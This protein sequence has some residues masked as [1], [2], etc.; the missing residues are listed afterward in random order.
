MLSYAIEEAS[1]IDRLAYDINLNANDSACDF[2]IPTADLP[3]VSRT[4]FGQLFLEQSE[5]ALAIRNRE[6]GPR[7]LG[8]RLL[9]WIEGAWAPAPQDLPEKRNPEWSGNS[10]TSYREPVSNLQDLSGRSQWL[11]LLRE[12]ENRSKF[13]SWSS[14]FEYDVPIRD[15]PYQLEGMRIL[16]LSDIHFVKSS[17]RS[18]LE[19]GYFVD[20]LEKDDQQIDLVLISGDIITVA[21]DDLSPE[22][23]RLFRRISEICP[24]CF[25]VHGNH[26]YHGH[27]PALISREMEKMGFYDINNHHIRITVDDAP[28]NIYGVDDAYFGS[29]RAPK[30]IAENEVNIVLT[31]NLDAIRGNFPKEIDLILSGHTHWGE[32]RVFDGSWIM[33]KWGYCNDLNKHTRHWDVLTNRTASFVHPGLARYY[34]PYPGLRHPPG[35][36]IHTLTGFPA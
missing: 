10:N 3:R 14:I 26:D 27:V 29:P 9:D 2:E 5:A 7:K 30:I 17:P 35:F 31:H 20:W 11:R 24:Q 6:R 33:G 36:V 32:L 23:L 12:G 34:V 13:T 1:T 25:F 16:H 15:L 19:L 28:L 8:E 18:M 22:C 4:D 21:P